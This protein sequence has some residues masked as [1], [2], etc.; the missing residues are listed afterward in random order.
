MAQS[1]VGSVVNYIVPDN[2]KA[3]G[4]I[5]AA[6]V[7]A[8]PVDSEHTV[9]G[10]RVVTPSDASTL[11]VWFVPKRDGRGPAFLEAA[12]S[13]TWVPGT[14]HHTDENVTPTPALVGTPGDSEV[15]A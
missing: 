5:V 9:N 1:N 15:S 2:S 7:V 13:S 3:K 10:K 11:H 14:W 6:Q 4:R 12:H 8:D